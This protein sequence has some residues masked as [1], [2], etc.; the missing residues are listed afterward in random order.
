[1]SAADPDK[2]REKDARSREAVDDFFEWRF[3]ARV[4]YQDII[5]S[6]LP[7]HPVSLH[8]SNSTVRTRDCSVFALIMGMPG[9]SAR[10][11]SVS[12]FNGWV[13]NRA[14]PY[15]CNSRPNTLW[16]QFR[17]MRQLVLPG[18][19]I[20]CDVNLSDD[21]VVSTEKALLYYGDELATTEHNSAP[22]TIIQCSP[23]EFSETYFCGSDDGCLFSGSSDG[24]RLSKIA[25]LHR[26]A[27][28][29]SIDSYLPA[30]AFV[31]T[32]T[33]K[34]QL[35]D[36][37]SPNTT[38]FNVGSKTC[39]VAFSPDVPFLFATGQMS[40]AITLFDQRLP[41]RQLSGVKEA[42][43][44]A[45][46]SIKWSPTDKNVFASGSIDTSVQLWSL[47]DLGRSKDALFAHNGHVAPIVAFDWSRDMP[48]TLASLSEDRLLEFWTI[49]PSQLEDY[50]FPD[51]R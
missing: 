28:D 33:S 46:T 30:T 17:E 47:K 48:W 36:T 43:D 26:P 7:R 41:N 9:T 2:A 3:Q 40:G 1:M 25:Q 22:I 12:L 10:P 31:A 38:P 6:V 49:A 16:G 44:S 45:V 5:M 29:I 35:I 27:L 8:F 14:S 21:I 4:F 15:C 20:A 34:L 19:P 51:H 18:T 42:H 32:G 39:S 11:P 37:R 23:L 24:N 50:L 13:P